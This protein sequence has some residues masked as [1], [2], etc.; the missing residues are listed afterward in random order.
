MYNRKF[1]LLVVFLIGEQTWNC[2]SLS[3]MAR[4]VRY[5][6][7]GRELFSER[8]TNVAHG[9]VKAPHFS[10]RITSVSPPVS[11]EEDSFQMLP[12][13]A[14]QVFPDEWPSMSQVRKA[15]RWGELVVL[16]ECNPKVETAGDCSIIP[17]ALEDESR[18]LIVGNNKKIVVGDVLTKVYNGDQLARIERLQCD[19]TIGYPQSA[20]GYVQPQPI[21]DWPRV[22][23]EDEDFA[24]VDKPEG[25]VTIGVPRDDLQSV[26]PFILHPPCLSSSS[27]TFLPRP[28]HR[29]DRRTRGLV[30][31]AKNEESMSTLSRAFAERNV[32]KTYTALV[33]G[34]VPHDS[35]TIDYPIDDKPAV[36]HWRVLERGTFF[37]MLEVQPTTGRNH[38][39]RRHLSYCLGHAIVGDNQYDNGG[40][41]KQFRKFGLFLCASAISLDHPVTE[42][43]LEVDI[44]LPEKFYEMLKSQTNPFEAVDDE[45]APFTIMDAVE[46]AKKELGEQF[47]TLEGVS[48]TGE[49]PID[50]SK[51]INPNQGDSEWMNDW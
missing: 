5:T 50:P 15:C 43:R 42:K 10:Y 29:L 7:R 2:K 44:T 17:G 47:S 19:T 46:Q 9:V 30:V 35:G 20:T 16:R 34:T 48:C 39:I 1:L 26:L 22:V 38:Q 37:T 8:A 27:T 18:N 4:V 23:Y 25:L 28:V 21:E 49:P 3:P 24:I 41:Y 32:Q 31:V 36:S 51:M 45:S 33:F 11:L 12:Q 6:R 40:A 14:Y 13:A